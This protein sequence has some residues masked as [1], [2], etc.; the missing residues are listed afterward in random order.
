V[1]E[2]HCQFCGTILYGRSDKLYCSS[3]CRRDRCRAKPR[4]IRLGD[5]TL[6]GS[7]WGRTA[8]IESVLIPQLERQYGANH[9][10]VQRA[11]RYAE[12]IRE[13]QHDEARREIAEIER[14]RRTLGVQ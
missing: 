7:E 8:D 6:W 11:R 10:A 2:R 12:Q 3:T 13:A 14:I 9:R 4:N 5:L 1:I